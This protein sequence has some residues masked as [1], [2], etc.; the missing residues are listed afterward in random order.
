MSALHASGDCNPDHCAECDWIIETAQ[1]AH[2]EKFCGGYTTCDICKDQHD[3]DKTT[4]PSCP[5]CAVV[6]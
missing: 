6:A 3:C 2:L 1:K 5:S 4:E